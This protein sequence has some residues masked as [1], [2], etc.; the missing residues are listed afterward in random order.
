[1]R[2]DCPVFECDWNFIIYPPYQGDERSHLLA[3]EREHWRDY[4]ETRLPD[5]PEEEEDA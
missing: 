5:N 4:H 1:M 3:V 2:I